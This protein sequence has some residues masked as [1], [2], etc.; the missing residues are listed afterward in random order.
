VPR[1]ISGIR[2][3]GIVRSTHHWIRH[4]GTPEANAIAF[5]SMVRIV[6]APRLQH[7]GRAQS[8]RTRSMC[9]METRVLS[10][11]SSTRGAPV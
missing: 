4:S 2:D 10:P 6:I 9:H 3:I 7:A 8:H 11:A 1:P 5:P